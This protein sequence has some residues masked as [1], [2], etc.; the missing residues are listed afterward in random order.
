MSPG[1]FSGLPKLPRSPGIFSGLLKLPR[2]QSL[3]IEETIPRPDE[4]KESSCMTSRCFKVPKPKP[5]IQKACT[6][7]NEI[8]ECKG[9]SV[10]KLAESDFLKA[11]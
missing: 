5:K 9:K 6:V 1:F 2:N 3:Q 11:T 7:W 4:Q 10:A 8:I